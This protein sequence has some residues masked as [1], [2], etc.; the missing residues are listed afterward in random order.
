ME[1]ISPPVRIFAVVIV[2]VGVAGM[3]ALRTMGGAGV[4]ESAPVPVAGQE[5]SGAREARGAASEDGRAR[6]QARGVEAC[7]QPGR[8][9]VRLPGG[10]RQGAA[11]A[12]RRRPPLVVPARASTSSPRPRPRQARSSA[13]PASSP[14]TSSTR[15]PPAALLAKL[16]T[17]QDPSVLVVTRLGEVALEL[18]GFVDRETV[19][20]RRERGPV[21]AVPGA[22]GTLRPPCTQGR[23]LGRDPA[24]NRPRRLVRRRDRGSPRRRHERRRARPSRAV[25]LRKCR[26]GDANR[27]RGGRGADGSR[28]RRPG[29][30]LPDMDTPLVRT[31][32]LPRVSVRWAVGAI[33]GVSA[34]LQTALAWRR[35]TPGYFPD[36]YMYAEL[37]RSILETGCHSSAET[38]TSC[39]SSI[40]PDLAGVALGR[41]RAGVPT[42][43][44]FNAVAMSLAAIPAFLLARRLCVGDR[45]ALAAAAPHLVL[46]ELLYSSAAMAEALAYP[47]AL[48]AAAAAVATLERPSARL[49]PWSSPVRARGAD[50]AAARG[51]ASLLHRS[52]ARGRRA[53][54]SAAVDRSRASARRRRDHRSGR[55]RCR[56]GPVRHGRALRRHHRLQSR[57]APGGDGVRCERARPRLCGRLG[58]RARR[59]PRPRART[60]PAAGTRRAWLRLLR[61]LLPRAAARAGSR[62]R[63]R[64]RVQ[65]RYAMYA[66]PLLVVAFVL[67]AARGWRGC[68]RTRCWRRWRRPRPLRCRSPDTPPAAARAS[69]SCSQRSASS[70]SGSATSASPRLRSPSPRPRSP[71]RPARPPGRGGSRCWRC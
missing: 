62:R 14:S 33:V 27:H 46:P 58:A 25:Q 8:A 68:A 42:L 59:V 35:P 24:R 19:A 23:P 10:R 9:A 3:L 26:P 7:P 48:A 13:A 69:R 50:A 52:R 57:A 71:S 40:R 2:L 28:P 43:Q 29:A 60:R 17:V 18:A 38:R 56:R 12:R 20:R 61:G 6:A 34:L 63:R 5:G 11:R 67:Y 21:S 1:K 70:S 16:D 53:R 55:R 30:E 44:A 47:L 41:R 54:P 37:G 39:R 31:A 64:R 36:E 45:L 15:P 4:D 22:A 66:L 51:A 49:Q 65:E 32:A